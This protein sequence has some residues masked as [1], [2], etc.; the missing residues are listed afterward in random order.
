MRIAV[1]MSGGV[2]SSLVVSLMQEVSDVKA[3]TFSIGFEENGFNEAG[4]AKEI[5][6]H[7]GTEHSEIYVSSLDCLDVIPDLPHMFREPFS[8]SS[9]IPTY[10][11]S[12]LAR[13]NMTVAL[14]GDGGDE[15]FAGYSRYH[16]AN[17]MWNKLENQPGW[18]RNF[19]AKGIRT[20]PIRA[21]DLL[22]GI[23]KPFIPQALSTKSPGDNFHRLANVISEG[24]FPAFY[25][26]LVSHWTDPGSVVRGG[27]EYKTNLT[28]LEGPSPTDNNVE[29]MM[30]WDLVSYLPDDIL[31]KV[32]R[33]S[34]AVGLEA[35]VPLL[36][37]RIVEFAWRLPLNFKMRNG[38]SKWILKEVLFKYIPPRL[39][40]RPKA[41]FGVPLALWLRGPLRDWAESLLDRSRI[42]SDG[43]FYPEPIL[44]YWKEF[45]SGKRRWEFH[46]WD[47]LIF[48]AWLKD[49][50]PHK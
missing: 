16:F 47:I 40:D 37:H 24:D 15:L 36:D 38:V 6:K 25:R 8:D 20:T 7:L 3:K 9:Q 43:I 12:K 1:A 39:L 34:M 28:G 44:Q 11:V 48:Q 35:R 14:S 26:N 46:L 32:D 45:L 33:A 41:G 17:T 23:A 49:Q 50:R 10:L 4:Y 31:T 21:W 27:H 19:I 5:A 30:Y 29:Q 2:D 22:G 18:L 42:E 13:Q